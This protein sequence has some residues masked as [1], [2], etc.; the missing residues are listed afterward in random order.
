MFSFWNNSNVRILIIS[1]IALLIIAGSLLYS[2][3]LAS[4]LLVQE[5]ERMELFSKSQELLANIDADEDDMLSVISGIV[6]HNKLIP[7]ILVGPGGNIQSSMNLGIAPDTGPEEKSKLEREYLDKLKKRGDPEA[8]EIDYGADKLL[9]YYDES[10][11]LRQLRLYPYLQLLIIVIFI[12]ILFISYYIATKNEQNK[13][14]VG[15]AKETAHQ[16]GTPVSSLM[17]WVELLKMEVE[18]NPHNAELVVELEKDV[19]RLSTVTER[20][21]KIGSV[22]EL[23][24]VSVNDFIEKAA[25]YVRKRMS[26]RV[27]LEVDN[28]V[29]EGANMSVNPALFEWVVENLLKNAL[30]A[31]PGKGTISITAI[32]APRHYIIDVSDTGKGIPKKLFKQV[33]KP[34]FTTK[35]RGWGLGLSLTRRIVEDYHQGKIFVKWSEVGKGTVFRVMLPKRKA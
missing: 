21:S 35:K 1:L 24:P 13:V 8:L 2:N 26:K 25:D 11:L 20:F 15:L 16:L 14:W 4:K 30:D 28:Q 32:E 7:V 22:P 17:A 31:I 29:P 6:T 9:I 3:H 5:V 34:G 18:T 10:H 33:F 27:N 12:S 23:I 19:N